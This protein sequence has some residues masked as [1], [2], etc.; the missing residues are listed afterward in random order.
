M[1][2]IGLEPITTREQILSLS[3]L[4]ISPSEL[5]TKNRTVCK[6]YKPTSFIYKEVHVTLQ[7]WLI[8]L[9]GLHRE[10]LYDLTRGG[11]AIATPGL[12]TL[13]IP[14]SSAPSSP[15]HPSSG[16]SSSIKELFDHFLPGQWLFFIFFPLSVEH[17]VLCF[18]CLVNCGI[19]SLLI[20][21]S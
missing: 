8:S 16:L 6:V 2:T 14:S 17:F 15:G 21:R 18:Y 4:P 3:C 19:E 7:A 12:D 13:R 9:F 1:L 20:L 11:A 5:I 10:T